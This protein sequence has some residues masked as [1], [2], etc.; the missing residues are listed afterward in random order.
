[1]IRRAL[2]GL[3]GRLLLALVFTSAVTL[4]VA[5]AIT[6]SPL[7]SRLRA[8]SSDALQ[9]STDALQREFAQAFKPRKKEEGG[10]ALRIGRAN[11]LPD[12]GYALRQR[13]GGARV[14]VA[15]D[16]FTN[17]SGQAPA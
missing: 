8:E 14:L 9:R 4:S 2:R 3:R 10:E 7:Q 6:L 13:T 1:M 12:A 5:A 16:S 11:R 15:D 17:T